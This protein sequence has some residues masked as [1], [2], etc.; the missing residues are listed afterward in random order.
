MQNDC[1]CQTCKRIIVASCSSD[2]FVCSTCVDILRQLYV[3]YPSL[4]PNSSKIL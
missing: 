2:R 3:K 4:N 1:E